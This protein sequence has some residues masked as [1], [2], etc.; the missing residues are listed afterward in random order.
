M[1]PRIGGGTGYTMA[2]FP[3]ESEIL[4]MTVWAL[5]G[6]NEVKSQKSLHITAPPLVALRV[7][8]KSQQKCGM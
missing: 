6:K 5:Q 1:A 2:P 8:F 7:H 3:L 4:T